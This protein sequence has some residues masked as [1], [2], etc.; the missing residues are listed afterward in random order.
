MEEKIILRYF[1]EN[2]E[3]K[4]VELNSKENQEL[5]LGAPGDET[6]EQ[7]LVSI[8]GVPEVKMEVCYKRVGSGAFAVKVPYPCA[9]TRTSK[10][11]LVLKVFYPGDVEKAV[12]DSIIECA[13]QGAIVGAAA[14]IPLFSTPATAVV[15]IQT[16]LVAFK[17]KFINC[18]GPELLNKVSYDIVHDSTSS[19]WHRV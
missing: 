13:K 11:R 17:E 8:N 16:G 14:A 12:K 1:G 3:M 6:W 18:I 19:D 9:Y 4:E 5:P 2:G 7:E 10:Q 15:A